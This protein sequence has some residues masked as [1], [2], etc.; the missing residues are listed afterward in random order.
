MNI[1]YKEGKGH[2]NWYFLG[3]W[4]LDSV[5]IN[6][7]YDPEVSTKIPIHFMEIDR[8]KNFKLSEWAPGSGTLDTDH[9]EP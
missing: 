8:R 9:I 5:R 6:T 4:P 1:I 7:A 2:T 3:R